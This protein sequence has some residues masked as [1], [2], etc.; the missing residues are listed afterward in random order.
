MLNHSFCRNS[1][2]NGNSVLSNT[3]TDRF[4][5]KI[6]NSCDSKK[7]SFIEGQAQLTIFLTNRGFRVPVIVKNLQGE[8]YSTESIS[9]AQHVVRLFEFRPGQILAQVPTT[10]NLFYQCGEYLGKMTC[11]MKVSH[12]YNPSA[13]LTV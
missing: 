3:P 7:T 4:V 12:F 6:L 2:E 8:Y 1:Q 10:D 9:E 5:L 13:C 11:A